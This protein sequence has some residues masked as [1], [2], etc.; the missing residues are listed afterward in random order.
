MDINLLKQQVEN[1]IGAPLPLKTHSSAVQV[2][3]SEVSQLTDREVQL[4]ELLLTAAN[5]GAKP[6]VPSKREDEL[7]SIELG[8]WIQERVERKELGCP[9]P[10]RMAVKPL[11]KV[12]MLPFLLSGEKSSGL[13]IQFSKLNKLL[14][15]YFG[16]DIVLLPLKEDWLIL[17]SED[18]LE[19]LRE[20]SK[21]G[22]SA[23]R[24]MLGELCQG[25]YEL[26]TNEWVGGGFYLAVGDLVTSDE[27]IV[28]SVVSLSET[29]L[30]GR[31]F[32]VT[33]HIHLPWELQ[34]ERLI[35]SIPESQR[36]QFIEENGIH[37]S[38]LKDEETRTTLEAFFQ[39]DCNMSETAK[40]LYV[41]RNTLI[42]RMD[43]FKQETGLDVRTFQDA[44]LVK[45]GLLLYKVT[46]RT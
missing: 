36:S 13:V 40:R 39:L 42:Y 2:T 24:E 10:D 22:M 38:V 26:I 33:E 6:L 17:V 11:L 23:E 28:G 44:V 29:L 30:L 1:I 20:E 7:R 25:L 5:E 15:S 34:L 16:G 18:L 45:L 4:I 35:Y 9:V 41:H 37:L 27:L 46:K 32:Y 12:P 31:M 14:R 19:D 3:R 21:E 8:E 43:K